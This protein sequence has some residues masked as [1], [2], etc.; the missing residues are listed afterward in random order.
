MAR[1]AVKLDHIAT[2]REVRQTTDPDPIAA[3][4]LAELGGADGIV[5]HLRE[6]RRHIQD[7]DLRILRRVVQ[8]QLILEM[9]STPEMTGTA[10]NVQPDRVLLLPERR[11]EVTTE[12]G[13]DF[14]LHGDQIGEAVATLQTSG[15]PVSVLVDP[16]PEQ[17]KLA[18]Q[19]D[20]SMVQLYAGDFCHAKT[21]QKRAHMFSKL[22]DAAKLAHR[23]NI[24]IH[25]G[26]HLSY[27]SIKTF[28]GFHE[29]EE[30]TIGHSI[31]C[32]SAL[33][34]LEKAVSEMVALIRYL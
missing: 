24:E 21:P 9:V 15:L 4:V 31:I 27:Q 14:V 22:V 7:R 19:M 34:G 23:L 5:I 2:L 13:L 25:V 6:D 12:G 11:D 3:A 26:H 29:I 33:V 10:L 28:K 1:L 20:V 30:F 32:R 18:H 17:I 16:D 8:T